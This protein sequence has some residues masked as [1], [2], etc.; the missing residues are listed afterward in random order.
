L[1]TEAE[2]FADVLTA[3]LTSVAGAVCVLAPDDPRLVAWREGGREEVV[4]GLTLAELAFLSR[5]GP[6]LGEVERPLGRLVAG[7]LARFGPRE[8]DLGLE[9]GC[10]VGAELRVLRRFARRVIGVDMAPAAIRCAAAQLAGQAVP[11]YRRLEGRSYAQT[12]HWQLPALSGCL[13]AV[14]DALSLPVRDGSADVV[15]AL[16]LLD[17][18]PDPLGLLRELYRALRP[19]GLLI[20]SS[21]FAWRDDLT[22]PEAQLGGGTVPALAEM[23][24]AAALGAILRGETP[25]APEL[26]LEVLAT[27]DVPWELEDHA[28]CVVRFEVHALAARRPA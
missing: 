23:G 12:H 6:S 20:V 8:A 18:V 1:T 9:A 15:M 7:W 10:G 27:A 24:S 21:P 11:R 14:G 13:A 2:P 26:D 17:N 22:P 5:Y 25:L 3:P 4:A 19:G 28:R 16:N